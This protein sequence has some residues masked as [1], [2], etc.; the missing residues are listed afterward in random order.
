[1]RAVRLRLV[2][3]RREAETLLSYCTVLEVVVF[4]H[5]MEYRQLVSLRRALL[6]RMSPC[7]HA[8]EISECALFAFILVI[9]YNTSRWTFV[10]P[11]SID[12]VVR[13][14]FVID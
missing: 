6:T 4:L 5:G 1:M 2:I 13:I 12:F 8:A 10:T 11:A 14:V 7:E 9:M 3:T